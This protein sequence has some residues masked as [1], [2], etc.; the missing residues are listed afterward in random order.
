[1]THKA[2]FRQ[3]WTHAFTEAD[4]CTRLHN[5]ATAAQWSRA[6]WAEELLPRTRRLDCRTVIDAAA[7]QTD[8]PEPDGGWRGFVL[9]S[10]MGGLYPGH[11]VSAS[12][13]QED[14]ALCALLAIRLLLDSER[15]LLPF[16]WR[17]EFAF[18][19]AEEAADSPDYPRFL[20]VWRRSFVYELLRL[21][22]E[23]TPFSTLQHTAMVHHVAMTAGR[24]QPAAQRR[25]GGAGT[26]IRRRRRA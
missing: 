7:E 18:C 4:F 11:R 5:A 17:M 26:G 19:S 25:A 12:A 2:I 1:M 9:Q 20:Q 6:R 24:A 23:L 13:E 16:D 14:F 22:S 15:Q 10:A 21:S 8:I 3:H